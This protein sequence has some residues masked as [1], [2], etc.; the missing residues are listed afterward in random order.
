MNQEKA[1]NA[2]RSEGCSASPVYGKDLFIFDMGNVVVRNIHVL[3]AVV[4]EWKLPQEDF[5]ADYRQYDFPLMDGTIPTSAY[6]CHIEKKFGVRVDG[7]PFSKHFS[8][9]PNPIMVA[10][11]KRLR[12][13]GKRVV[14]G[15]NTFAPHWDILMDMGMIDLFDA[16]YPSHEIG[17]SKPA[18]QYFRYI[19]NRERT[20]PRRTFFVDDYQENIEAA[21]RLGIDSMH[22]ADDPPVLG[23]MT[24]D[25][26]LE[27]MFGPIPIDGRG[28]RP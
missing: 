5:F 10:L 18:P 16:V 28:V 14:C 20:T 22:Y 24:A 9:E 17:M 11:I 7:E 6:W 26:K 25:E 3:Q 12:G 4:D 19:L 21:A 8:P 2:D 23:G 1:D 13:M 27:A 15:S